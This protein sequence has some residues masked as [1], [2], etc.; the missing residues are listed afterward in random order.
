MQA[1]AGQVGAPRLS[2]GI[3]HTSQHS[4]GRM[5]APRLWGTCR[6]ISALLDGWGPPGLVGT[7]HM[8]SKP[9][10]LDLGSQAG[11]GVGTLHAISVLSWTD[12]ASQAVRGPSTRSQCTPMPLSCCTLPTTVHFTL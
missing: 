1:S 3:L 4:A 8:I 2:G 12:G 5:G 6:V 10:W 9:L 11:G 7:L